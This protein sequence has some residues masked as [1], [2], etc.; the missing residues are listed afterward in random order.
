MIA[1][2][3]SGFEPGRVERHQVQWAQARPGIGP[4]QAAAI[5]RG[6]A[7][8]RILAVRAGGPVYEVKVLSP[9]GRVHVIRVDARTGA[10]L[11]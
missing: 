10:V 3:A 11:P 2:G 7:G 6:V 5:A 8:G 1:A 4:D 9:D